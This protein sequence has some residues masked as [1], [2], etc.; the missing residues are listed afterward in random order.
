MNKLNLKFFLADRYTFDPNSNLLTDEQNPEIIQRLGSNES[1]I[2]HILV[3]N[4]HKVVKRN[5]L[6]DFVWRQQGIEVDD[7][8]LTQAISTL[9]KSLDDSIKSPQF[10]KTVPKQGY[11]WIAEVVS[12]GYS[13]RDETLASEMVSIET[14][15]EFIT[16]PDELHSIETVSEPVISQQQEMLTAV[17]PKRIN[18]KRHS[19]TLSMLSILAALLAP[20]IIMLFVSVST[21]QFK[22]ATNVG[23]IPVESPL[24]NPSF[25]KWKPVIEQ[26][27]D[28]YY[29]AHHGLPS[30]V[31]LIVTGGKE[32]KLVLNFVYNQGNLESTST[33]IL[34][35]NQQNSSK[36]C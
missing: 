20:F 24:T 27:V 1:R 33:F 25:D 12:S 11:Q 26:C 19:I 32:N 34:L 2:L 5:E 35:T 6:H 18:N 31:Q 9:R 22:L 15:A 28:D 10:I 21:T 13:Q 23:I 3:Q 14:L 16:Q 17:D 8:S 36:I 30:P 4:A 29:Q 7:S